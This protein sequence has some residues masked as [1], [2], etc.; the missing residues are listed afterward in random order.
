[1]DIEKSSA[2]RLSTVSIFLTHWLPPFAYAALIFYLSSIPG[3][4]YPTL[5]FSAD[6]FLHLG[7][8]GI[9]GYLLARAL[10]YYHFKKKTLFII[11][12]SI[13]FIYGVSDELHQFFVPYR[14]PSVIDI[15][16][17][18]IGSAIG[19]GIYVKQRSIL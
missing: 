2:S 19:V 11:A 16:A 13:C 5:F 15:I 12:V 4:T 9:L 8:Y 7:E 18:G 14:C 3:T 10:G 17:D 1:M 6:K